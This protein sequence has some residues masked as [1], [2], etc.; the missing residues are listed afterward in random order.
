MKKKIF[1][2]RVKPKRFPDFKTWL[3][4]GMFQDGRF[5]SV[6]EQVEFYTNDFRC[7]YCKKTSAETDMMQM[8]IKTIG[9]WYQCYDIRKEGKHRFCAENKEFINP[10]GVKEHE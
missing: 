6:K 7:I 9:I 5:N 2:S 4:W 10:D 8:T 3:K 1:P